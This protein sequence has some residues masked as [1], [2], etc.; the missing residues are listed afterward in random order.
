MT[1]F[2]NHQKASHEH[3]TFSMVS[4]HLSRI[5]DQ[6]EVHRAEYVSALKQVAATSI[7]GMYRD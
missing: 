6:D 2:D 3:S 5:Q 7:L 4:D 1:D